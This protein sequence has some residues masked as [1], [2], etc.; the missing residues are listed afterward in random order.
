[1]NI[2]RFCSELVGRIVGA[3]TMDI[4]RFCI[5][6]RRNP[7]VN[8][9]VK[10]LDG[11]LHALPRVEGELRLP[12]CEHDALDAAEPQLIPPLVCERQD[13]KK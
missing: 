10:L 1:M 9:G 7:F 3:T 13:K 5:D 11:K 4:C 8:G 6:G 2:C 12:Q